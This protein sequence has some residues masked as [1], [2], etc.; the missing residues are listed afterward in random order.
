L[1]VPGTQL[2]SLLEHA[3]FIKVIDHL[4]TKEKM[5]FGRKRL[6]KENWTGLADD[7]VQ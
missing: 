6:W 4:E 5:G 3:G 1:D 7:R 2:H